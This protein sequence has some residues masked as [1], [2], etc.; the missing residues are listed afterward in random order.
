MPVVQNTQA[1]KSIGFL[2][3]DLKYSLTLIRK[4]NVQSRFEQ[5]LPGFLDVRNSQSG[6]LQFK[7]VGRKGGRSSIAR[8]T[9][10]PVALGS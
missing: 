10:R 4:C 2:K 6:S 3:L 7:T 5:T 8:N 1:K 9:C